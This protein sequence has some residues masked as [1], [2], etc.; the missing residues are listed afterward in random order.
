MMR[1]VNLEKKLKKIEPE[2]K[3]SSKPMR[4]LIKKV[5]KEQKVL[6][7]ESSDGSY[8]NSP[9]KFQSSSI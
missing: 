5:L 7:N 4:I 3:L 6:T 2:K 8:K 9:R 1:Q